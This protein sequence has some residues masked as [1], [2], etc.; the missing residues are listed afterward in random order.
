MEL[1]LL[2]LDELVT[3]HLWNLDSDPFYPWE[4]DLEMRGE[5]PVSH[6]PDVQHDCDKDSIKM[7][8]TQLIGGVI[9]SWMK[10]IEACERQG[11]FRDQWYI[12]L[13]KVEYYMDV[14][15]G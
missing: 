13:D 15:Y 2:V 3:I 5:I 12:P 8:A 4:M 14:V 6:L 10:D 11:V 9:R 7:N 1:V